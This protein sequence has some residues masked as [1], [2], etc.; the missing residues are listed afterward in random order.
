[1]IGF[2]KNLLAGAAAT[3]VCLLAGPSIAAAQSAENYFHGFYF[4]GT[5]G[6]G[7]AIYEGFQDPTVSSE[8]VFASDLNLDGIIGAIHTGFNYQIDSLFGDGT[9]LLVGVEGDVAFTDFR[10]RTISESSAVLIGDVDLLAS[11]RARLGIVINEQ[12]LVFAT[13]GIAFTDATWT[14]I[15]ASGT[16]GS[17]KFND[18]GGVVGGGAEF[19]LNRVVSLRGE[20]LYYFFDDRRDTS[21]LPNGVAGDFGKFDDAFIARAGISVNLGGLGIGGG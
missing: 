6:G 15:T 18:V 2:R 16:A 19:A 17:A 11:I 3:A 4:G 21:G 5:V 14:S 13:A 20:A 8:A 12:I 7:E 1:M 9:D 10:D